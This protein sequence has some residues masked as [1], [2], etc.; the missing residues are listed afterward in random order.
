[1]TVTEIV[2]N[3]PHRGMPP[4]PRNASLSAERLPVLVS[5]QPFFPSEAS[6]AVINT[7]ACLRLHLRRIL[8]TRLL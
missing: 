1:M 8:S 5:R 2:E 6:R 3:G 7:F 4:C